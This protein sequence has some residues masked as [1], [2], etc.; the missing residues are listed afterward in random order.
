MPAW[1]F[2]SIWQQVLA[3]YQDPL[4]MPL[5]VGS[6]VLSAMAFLCFALPWTLLAFIDPARLRRFKIQ[7]KPFQVRRYFWP[8]IARISI[9]SSIMLLLMV[10]AW[11]IFRHINTIHTGELP[12]WYW[13]ILQMGVFIVLDDF[14]Y[15]WMHR[16]MHHPL[17]LRH[18]HVV[19]HRIK[20]TCALDGNYFHWLEFV[21]TGLLTMLGPL[22]LG[23][24][25]YVFWLWIIIRQFEAAD[26]HCGYDFPYNPV[27]LIPFY[28]GAVY[29]DFH[30]ARFKGN[31]AGFLPYLDKWMGNTYVPEY[32]RY[33]AAKKRRG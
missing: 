22:L 8:N 2:A 17:L 33:L 29:H 14:L 24:H 25:L 7:Q 12:A 5:V 19:H 20:N 27:K 4:F 18:V 9:N 31:Y 26:G 15:Y 11:P 10:L 1:D 23:A 16:T 13:I 6:T 30:H 21:A 3:S 28:H 32:L